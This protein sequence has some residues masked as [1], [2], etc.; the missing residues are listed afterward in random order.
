M[1][2]L[3]TNGLIATGFLFIGGK[4]EKPST[5]NLGITYIVQAP[6]TTFH[7]SPD[8]GVPRSVADLFVISLLLLIFCV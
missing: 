7:L 2:L 8:K 1:L 4:T 6:R 5:H 3:R